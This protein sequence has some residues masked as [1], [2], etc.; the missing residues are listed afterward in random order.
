VPDNNVAADQPKLEDRPHEVTIKIRAFPYY[1]DA[2]D[3]V[4]GAKVRREE[5]ARR[6][7]TVSLSETDYQ[8]A[9]RFD[10]IVTDEAGDTGGSIEPADALEAGSLSFHDATVE[11]IS[12][13]LKQEKPTVD[14]VVEEANNDPVLAQK[15]LD[16]E[17]H[18]T[19]QQPRSTLET[20]LKEIIG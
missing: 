1:V 3:L 15:L 9:V 18:A 16:G 6:G 19:G 4:S 12:S 20:Q 8:R 2:I 17:N 14:R 5:L 10:A 7:D 13:W 11:D